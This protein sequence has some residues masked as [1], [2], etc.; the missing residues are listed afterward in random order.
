[1]IRPFYSPWPRRHFAFLVSETEFD[2]IFNRI[3][4]KQLKYWSDPAQT[5][6][7]QINH[8]DGGRGC[9]FLDPNGH[10]LEIITRPY[11]G[12]D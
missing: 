6:P 5:K 11:G 8:N 4:Q 12:F 7:Q 3:T 9:Y 10:F 1:M 2:D